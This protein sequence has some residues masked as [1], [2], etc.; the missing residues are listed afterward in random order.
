MP[1]PSPL[2]KRRWASLSRDEKARLIASGLYDRRGNLLDS[3]GED[4]VNDN[5]G[6]D[7]R[8]TFKP[9]VTSPS[10]LSEVIE[11]EENLDNLVGHI[12]R[13]EMLDGLRR[14]FDVL[15]E[16]MDE[17][18]DGEM[19]LRADVIRIA[20]GEGDPPTMTALARRHGLGKTAVSLRCRKLLKQLGIEPSRFMRPEASVRVMRASF[21]VR[22]ALKPTPA[23]PGK[24]SPRT[25]ANLGTRSRPR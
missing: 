18:S 21:R 13:G 12:R 8:I 6:G 3:L 10:A 11:A 20:I 22:E 19:R 5:R 4:R 2:A 16:G 23:P 24:E 1:E 17:S 9:T 14:V 7:M 25:G 15:L